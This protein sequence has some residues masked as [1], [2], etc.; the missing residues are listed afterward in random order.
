MNNVRFFPGLFLLGAGMIAQQGLAQSNA[1][2]KVAEKDVAMLS[3][4]EPIYP[5]DARQARV[6]VSVLLLRPG[7]AG[8]LQLPYTQGEMSMIDALMILSNC[9]Q[10]LSE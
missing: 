8:C 6:E 7:P 9:G 2:R 1:P 10:V 5:D 3:R 4:V